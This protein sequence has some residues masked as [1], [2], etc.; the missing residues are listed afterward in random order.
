MPEGYAPCQGVRWGRRLTV[1]TV[2]SHDRS[3]GGIYPASPVSPLRT[4][5]DMRAPSVDGRGLENR[6]LGVENNRDVRLL[7]RMTT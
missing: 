4:E 2:L 7:G 1:W 6:G 5:H 3:E